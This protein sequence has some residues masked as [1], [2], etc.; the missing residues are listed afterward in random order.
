MRCDF[1]SSL[2]LNS[3]SDLD[4]HCT[5]IENY[6]AFMTEDRIGMQMVPLDGNPHNSVTFIAHP[7]GVADFA[8]SFDG[9]YLF[10]AG[11]TDASV[12]MWEINVQV[13]IERGFFMYNSHTN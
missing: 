8:Y 11:G 1:S 3:F 7:N 6:L 5:Q 9:R 13:R 10:T 4:R 2:H 12:H